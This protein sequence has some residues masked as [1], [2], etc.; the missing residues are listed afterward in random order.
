MMRETNATPKSKHLT[1][2]VE[3]VTF[4]LTQI[5]FIAV[6]VKNSQLFIYSTHRYISDVKLLKIPSGRSLIWFPEKSLQ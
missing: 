1:R 4:K 5:M 2:E 6:R 3:N